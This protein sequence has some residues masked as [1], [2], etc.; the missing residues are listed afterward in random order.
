MKKLGENTKERRI[1][2]GVIAVLAD[3]FLDIR[4]DPISNFRILKYSETCIKRTPSIK[5]TL[6]EVPLFIALIYFK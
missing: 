2:L 1:I 3:V 4:L 5:R 6:A